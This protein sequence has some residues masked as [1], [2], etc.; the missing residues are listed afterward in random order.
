MG[1]TIFGCVT[2]FLCSLI[3]FRLMILHLNFVMPSASGRA[4]NVPAER[5]LGQF[6][7]S[8]VWYKTIQEGHRPLETFNGKRLVIL[9][10]AYIPVAHGWGE[11]T[12]A[13]KNASCVYGE[14]VFEKGK[15]SLLL[16]CKA[17]RNLGLTYM[18]LKSC[19]STQISLSNNW[20]P[21][22]QKLCGIHFSSW[23]FWDGYVVIIQ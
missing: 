1:R 3:T 6:R 19:W 18:W 14:I 10:G 2:P 9:T 22:C 4:F 11:V 20:T 17:I 12:G 23:F 21:C 8:P 13:C 15:A 16:V 7:G 5:N